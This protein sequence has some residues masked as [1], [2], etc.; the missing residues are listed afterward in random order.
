VVDLCKTEQD[1]ASWRLLSAGNALSRFRTSACYGSPEFGR[2]FFP[3]SVKL[4]QL[5]R[6]RRLAWDYWVL[7]YVLPAVQRV[8][9]PWVGLRGVSTLF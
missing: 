8:P 5:G 1:L 3:H 7:I 6:P 2:G 4:I 9:F